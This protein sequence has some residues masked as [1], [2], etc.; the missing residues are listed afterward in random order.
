MKI[1]AAVDRSPY[2]EKVIEMAARIADEGASV[3]LINVAPREPDVFGQQL[4]R[5]VIT[6]PVSEELQDRKALLDRL[7]TVLGNDGIK[8]E[9]LLIRG[10]PAPVIVREAKRWGAELVIMG[11][12]GRGKLYQKVM[13]SVSEGV[14]RSRQFPVLVIPKP[15]AGEES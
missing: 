13:G 14:L 9:T 5:K 6:D 10:D 7:A 8:C 2:S 11:S 15:K 1:L 12:H 3:L 4:T